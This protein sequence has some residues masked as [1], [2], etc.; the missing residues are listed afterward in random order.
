LLIEDNP[1]FSGSLPFQVLILDDK[2][3]AH[4]LRWVLTSNSGERVFGQNWHR[5]ELC[6][7]VRI[8]L[9]RLA[10]PYFNH[11]GEFANLLAL[12]NESHKF[13]HL[14]AINKNLE[15]LKRVWQQFQ[16]SEYVFENRVS[17]A[18][19][20]TLYANRKALE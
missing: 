9:C 1:Y 11:V 17:A 15:H 20:I 10:C 4:N 2:V 5:L 7:R 13:W 8:L 12:L 3:E 6:L 16:F 14:Q 18:V 19:V